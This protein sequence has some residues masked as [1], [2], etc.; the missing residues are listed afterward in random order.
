M[1]AKSMRPNP[2]VVRDV[3]IGCAIAAIVFLG[4]IPHRADAQAVNPAAKA[5]EVLSEKKALKASATAVQAAITALQKEVLAHQADPKVLLRT[6][7]TYFIENPVKEPIHP[8]AIIDALNT[9]ISPDAPSD[10]YVKWQLLSGLR[11]KQDGKAAHDACIALYYAPRPLPRP[12]LSAADKKELNAFLKYVKSSDDA[13]ALTQKLTDQVELWARRNGPV[14]AYRDELSSK[15][16]LGAEAIAARLEDIGQRIEAGYEGEKETAVIADAIDKWIDSKPPARDLQA[17][18]EQVTAWLNRGKPKPAK[19]PKAGRGS[20]IEQ[21]NPKY[22]KADF[23]EPMVPFPPTYYEHV[24]FV[25]DLQLLKR[26]FRNVRGITDSVQWQWASVSARQL[27]TTTLTD[28]VVT[29]EEYARIAADR[30][31]LKK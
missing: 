25:P 4:I 27:D 19:M 14:I 26:I 22:A 1:G 17:M 21:L 9:T 20:R 30:E 5:A 3:C 24:E 7:S 15:L 8:L 28:L 18:A 12:G 16:P 13:T 10:S 29:L 11:G 31:A 2:R 6:K 23:G